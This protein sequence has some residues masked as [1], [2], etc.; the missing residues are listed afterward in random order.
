MEGEV[1]WLAERRVVFAK[2]DLFDYNAIKRPGGRRVQLTVRMPEEYD[3]ALARISKK[4]GL[5]R[6]DVVRMAIK[7][8][9][10]EHERGQQTRPFE[11][12]KHLLGVAESGI[13]D[14]GQSHR[15][16]LIRKLK[17]ASS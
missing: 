17:K 14:L 9:L 6:S 12:V 13:S 8:F 16:H 4:L 11:S 1:A 15:E 2:R 10:E 5:K 7:E 3:E